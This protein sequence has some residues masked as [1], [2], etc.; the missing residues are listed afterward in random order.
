MSKMNFE[1]KEARVLSLSLDRM[2]IS[3]WC[4]WILG[5]DFDQQ[6]LNRVFET[7]HMTVWKKRKSYYTAVAAAHTRIGFAAAGSFYIW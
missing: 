4:Q 6:V 7:I 2:Q 1:K 3:P 5:K